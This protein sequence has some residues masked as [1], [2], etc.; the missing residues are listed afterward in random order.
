MQLL[1]QLRLYWANKTFN[2]CVL[3]L[4]TL[5]GVVIPA[6]HY[7][8]NTWVTPLILGVIAAALAERDDSFTGRLK[9]ITLTFICFA[10]AAFS[11][12]ILFRTPI[13][14]AIGLFI[15][16]F[17]FIMLGAMG[18]RYA[19]IAF[20]SLLI[21]IYTML[22]AHQS[23]NIWF[24][25]L[26]LLMGSAWYYLVS[27][28]WH[29]FWPMQPVQQDLANV[30]VQLA[31]YFEAKSK[32]FHP[33]SN[34]VPQPH[35]ITEANLNAATVNA[36]NQAKATF[37]TRSKRGHVDSTS[38]RFLKI[39][40][41]A[42]DIHE[43]ASST[44]YRYQDL[45]DNFGRTDVL[46][47]F[48]HLLETQ[49]KACREIAH[50]IRIGRSYQHGS[51]SVLALDELQL[52]L[53]YL[54]E[55]KRPEWKMLLAQLGYLFN[56]LATVE[57]QLCNVSN[58][59]VS[60]PEEDVLDD[61][62]AHTLKTLWL[63]I[64]ANLNQDSLLFRHAVRMSI[65]LTLGYGILQGLG[66]E[67]GYWILL[68]TLFVCQPNYAATRQ[69][70]TSRII[71][72]LAGLLIGVPLLTFFPSQESQ[73][74]L[75]VFSGVMFFA[76]RLNNYGY[77]TGFITLLVLFCF[78]QLGEGF[79]VVLPRL[80]DTLIGCA[81]AVG[82]VIFILPDWQSKRLHKV[83]ADAIDANKQYLGQIIGQYRIG[84][85]DNLTYRIARRN[86][87]NQDAALAAAVSNML[88]E[89]GK[90]RTATDESFRF[91]TLNHALL[92]YISALGAH[93]TRI[94]DET[95]HQLVLDSHRVIHQHL[96]ILYQQLFT[97]CGDCD[98]ST[99]EDAGLEKRLA[100]WREEDDSSARMV[101]QQLHLI[102]RMLPELHSLASKFAVRV[103]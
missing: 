28:L 33:V 73:L 76:F 90:Y 45:A 25:P 88:A 39:Y 46:F 10:I 59:D 85:K 26:L 52:S 18:S 70:L 75:I 71:G 56:N 58:P 65:A 21:A 55:Q 44:H 87:H 22:G 91:L 62:E 23:T 49:A 5:L 54:Q 27:M 1:N 60:K 6:W 47:R 35:R 79:A 38:D 98:T 41:L 36:L 77:A 99:I 11:I 82:A 78:N 17:G 12:E 34:L 100:E 93:R 81:L 32:L 66:L 53:T 64:K 37:L 3:I 57:K 30:F 83:M 40:F 97:H 31:N 101:L 96:D 89:P 2:Y 29:A 72:T 8:L 95:V 43:R 7:N 92:S 102:Y 4:I 51:E 19:S 50:S 42:Q 80:A 103:G 74:V 9:S 16:T 13:L 86:A 67:R 69:K 24:Q 61:T 15:S 48:R 14:F 84:K 68:T 20:G 94:D 63:R